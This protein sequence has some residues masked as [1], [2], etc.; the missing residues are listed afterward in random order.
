LC[1]RQNV[2]NSGVSQN[3]A[4]RTKKKIDTKLLEIGND[5]KRPRID[6][7]LG[8]ND[9]NVIILESDSDDDIIFFDSDSETTI[10]ANKPII[11]KAKPVEQLPVSIKYRSD[12]RIAENSINESDLITR[13]A[14]SD[15]KFKKCFVRLEKY[16]LE[17]IKKR[18]NIKLGE[19]PSK[20]QH[21]LSRSTSPRKSATNSPVKSKNL[22]LKRFRA[23]S[24]TFPSNER[25]FVEH[26]ARLAHAAAPQIDLDLDAITCYTMA[27]TTRAASQQQQN[28][29]SSSEL[30]TRS[31]TRSGNSASQSI[32]GSSINS[33]MSRD[34]KEKLNCSVRGSHEVPDANQFVPLVNNIAP[35]SPAELLRKYSTSIGYTCEM[36]KLFRGS[37]ITV[38]QCLECENLRKCPESFYDRSIPIDTNYDMNEDEDESIGVNWI[39]KCLSNESYLN[40]NSKY[41]CDVC[42]SQQEAMIHTQ[43]TQL[44]SILIL[45]LLSYGITSR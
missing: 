25:T 17:E 11:E 29:A 45:H 7:V 35:P 39:S 23:K 12:K 15:V 22:E 30:T 2:L 3:S 14:L 4:Q 28:V 27:S 20:K 42:S 36:D 6:T 9:S 10:D 1:L 40:D 24:K 8:I 33:N 44:P 16:D 34:L 18:H 21:A 19:S 38:T 13:E 5:S 43:Y 37:S 41:M 32:N 26:V 31:K